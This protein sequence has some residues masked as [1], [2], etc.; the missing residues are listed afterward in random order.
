MAG[1]FHELKRRNVVRVG[2]AYI[3]VGWVVVQIAQLL[4]EAFGTPDWVIKT[5]IVLIGIGFPFAMLFAWAFELTPEGLKKTR[6]VDVSSSITPKTGQRLNHVIIASL[7]VALAYFIWER[8]SHVQVPDQ[9]GAVTASADTAS[10]NTPGGA[11]ETGTELRSIAV[12]PFVN[13]SSDEEQEYFADGLTEEILN[14]LAKTPDLLVTARTTSF[15]YKGSTLPVPEIATALGVDHIL[16]GSVRRGGEKLRITAQLIRAADGFHLW[17]ETFD[18]T[19]EDIIA[20]QEEIAVQIATALETAMDPK[21]L[22]EMMKAGTTSVPAYEAF[23]TGQGAIRAADET[24]DPYEGLLALESWERAIEVDPEFSRA[25]ARLSFF[26]VIQSSSNQL[27]AGITDLSKE[28]MLARRDDLLDRAI[29]YAK[30]DT[31]RQEYQAGKALNKHDLLR[32]R[33]IYDELRRERPNDERLVFSQHFVYSALGLQTEL[34]ALIKAAHET[35][36]FTRDA[37]NQYMQDLRTPD[38]TD[39]MRVIGHAAI[40]QYG[41]DVSIMYQAHRQLLWAGDVDGASQILPRIQSSRLPEQNRHLVALRQLCAEQ[42]LT[43]AQARFEDGLEKF[44]GDTSVLWLSR[45]IMGDIE[46]S[47]QVLAP[48]DEQKDFEELF[49]YLSYTSFDATAYPNF[50][51]HMAGQGLENRELIYPPYRCSR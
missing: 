48:F 43:E 3:V 5:V 15:G 31:E 13:M 39:L 10:A 14:S 8:Q 25:L 51:E 34:T 7:V 32:A 41:N 19:M 37:A 4:F 40:E 12:L 17:S 22:Q 35:L 23:L 47:V 30:D 29:R 18:R 16:E 11:G 38:D 46:G 20:I 9:V 6:D 44:P 24:G 28:E 50:M 45:L 1:L 36:E 33:R 26:W 2:V 27:R 49:S 21:A 42:R